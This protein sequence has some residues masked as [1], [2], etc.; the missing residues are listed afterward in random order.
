MA[1]AKVEGG[2]ITQFPYSESDLRKDHS[3][4]SF[5]INALS[6]ENIRSDYSVV[7]VE[8]SEKP[9]KRGHKAVSSVAQDGGKWVE[10]WE[11]VP[12]TLKEVEGSDIV[13]TEPPEEQGKR[14]ELVDPEFSDGEWRQVWQLVAITNWLE[15]RQSEYGRPVTQIEFI[16]ENGLEAWQAKV[17][18]IKGRWPKA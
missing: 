4:T 12:K 1:Y 9:D 2:N 16:T 5:P 17:A 3:K 7:E 6:N 15:G 14:A 18:E 8:S 11:L 13:P 10:S